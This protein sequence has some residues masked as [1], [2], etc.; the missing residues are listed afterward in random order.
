VISLGQQKGVTLLE[1]ILVLVITSAIM[2]LG[3]RMYIQYQNQGYGEQTKYNVDTLLQAMT[4]FYR[5]QCNTTGVLG[6]ASTSQPFVVTMQNLAPYLPSNWESK[7]PLS[8]DYVLQFNPTVSASPVYVH[9]CVVITKGTPCVSTT[10]ALPASQA[11]VIIWNEQ[12]A[13]L[14]PTSMSQA[15]VNSYQSTLSADCVSTLNG[16]SIQLCPARAASITTAKNKIAADQATLALPSCN[17]ACQTATTAQLNTDQAAYTSTV[18][19]GYLVWQRLPSATGS[20]Q[21]TG[22]WLMKPLLQQFDLQYSHDQMLE[23][24]SGYGSARNYLCGG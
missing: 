20:Q 7:N 14:T 18:A 22:L 23:L 21:T 8:K 11:Q 19:G 9:A 12:V 4:A 13:V 1:I 17:A 6:T 2:M 16:S 5:A 10:T 15:T 3:L 24:N